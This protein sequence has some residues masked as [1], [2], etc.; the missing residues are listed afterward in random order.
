MFPQASLRSVSLFNNAQL[1]IKIVHFIKQVSK[2]DMFILK[3][4]V[5]VT[6]HSRK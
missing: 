2:T 4:Y 6:T 5:L 3:S 1:I